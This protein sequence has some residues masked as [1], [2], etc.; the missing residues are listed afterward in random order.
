MHPS[1]PNGEAA[2]A[3]LPEQVYA[4]PEGNWVVLSADQRRMVAHHPDLRTALDEASR[5]GE[6]N[7]VILKAVHLREHWVI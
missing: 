4:V 7:G 3:E 6:D 2:V 1:K 5:R